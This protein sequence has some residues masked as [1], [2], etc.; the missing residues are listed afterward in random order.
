MYSS[1]VFPR[2]RAGHKGL[3]S[4]RSTSRATFFEL[5]TN[6]VGTQPVSGSNLRC[7][8][9]AVD[10]H[11]WVTFTAWLNNKKEFSSEN[12]HQ[13]IH[14]DQPARLKPF[15][16]PIDKRQR[17]TQ[18]TKQ[19]GMGK[20]SPCALAHPWIHE[21]KPQTTGLPSCTM[22]RTGPCCAAKLGQT[23]AGPPCSP[24]MPRIGNSRTM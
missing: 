17:F 21:T 14:A 23:I 7:C 10:R 3:E 24:C 1:A 5:S 11:G 13:F 6:R 4:P 18:P 20:R 16:L 8:A 2:D 9:S 15:Y 19:Y 22:I 12:A